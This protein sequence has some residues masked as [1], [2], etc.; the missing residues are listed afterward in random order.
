[1]F[2]FMKKSKLYVVILIFSLCIG[3][4]SP[5]IL[6][7]RA[8]NITN[9]TVTPTSTNVSTATN[10]TITFTPV[11][12]I[13]TGTI[14]HFSYDP[15]F[16]GGAALGDADISITGTNITSKVCSGFAAGYFICTLSNSAPVTTLV[17][18]V[19][20][21]TNKL[22]TPASAGNYSF[23]VTANI[24]GAG[25][26]YDA[27]AGLAYIAGGNQ[28]LIKSLV[29]SVLALDLYNAGTTTVMTY[30][31][32]CDIGVLSINNVNICSYDIGIGTNNTAGAVLKAQ[33]G[34]AMTNGST[35]L[36]PAS[37]SVLTAGTE[38]YG[39]HISAQ[40]TAFTAQ[41]SYATPVQAVPTSA[42][43]I[44][45]SSGVSNKITLAE[46]LTIRHSAAISTSTQTGT[47][48]Q[49]VSYTV[50]SR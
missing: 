47:Y 50:F 10:V 33:A 41:A 11:T 4:L 49:T 5:L 21:A 2:C 29:V 18:A 22:T 36:T 37:G 48:T 16:T 46:H 6:K 27:G 31:H 26:T 24:G 1:M 32:V 34:G 39:F 12:A 30:P 35:S 13:T 14:M 9:I 44:S 17:T 25:T 8:A 7:V 28:I 40:G 23:S 3:I 45:Q 15:A 19:I 20:G 43:S 38:G 42:T